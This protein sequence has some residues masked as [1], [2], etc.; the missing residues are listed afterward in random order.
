M[1]YDQ[2]ENVPGLCDVK[3]HI[4][5]LGSVLHVFVD[6]ASR[7]E[8]SARDI[9]SRI[10]S[11]TV[12][13]KTEIQVQERNEIT[14]EA[15]TKPSENMTQDTPV[16]QKTRRYPTVARTTVYYCTVLC[17]EASLVLHDDLRINSSIT[18]VLRI[19]LNNLVV[20]LRPKIDMSEKLRALN[21]KVREQIE[22]MVLVEDAQIDNQLSVHGRYDF[23]VIM[24]FKEQT[25]LQKFSPL[26]PIERV[27]QIAFKSSKFM[28][29][30]GLERTPFKQFYLHTIKIKLEPVRLQAEDVFFY[31][32]VD[33]MESFLSSKAE[34]PSVRC[35]KQDYDDSSKAHVCVILPPEILCRSNAISRP[36]NIQEILIDPISVELSVHASVKLYIALDQTP[37]NFNQ[38]QRRQIF[39]TSYSLGHNVAMHY[40]SGALVKAGWVVGSLEILGNPGGFARTVGSGMRDFVQ[41]PYEGILV[42]PWAFMAGIT[43]G[44]LSLVKHFTAGTVVSLT[45]L[46]SSVARNMDRLSLDNEH[47]ARTERDRRT[48]QPHGLMHGLGYGLATFGISLLGGIGG[49]AQQPIEAIMEGD[50]SAAGVVGGV[51]RGVLGA[52]TKPIGGA[53]D[54]FLHTGQGLL[55]GAG[56]QQEQQPRHLPP[57]VV[58]WG[59]ASNSSVKVSSKH[60]VALPVECRKVLISVEATL[61]LH[62]VNVNPV[63]VVLTPEMLYILC[64]SSDTQLYAIPILELQ[65]KACGSDPTLLLLGRVQA[66]KRKTR[67]SLLQDLMGCPERVHD[68]VFGTDS[69]AKLNLIQ[70]HQF[71]Q[72]HDANGGVGSPLAAETSAVTQYQAPIYKDPSLIQVEPDHEVDEEVQGSDKKPNLEAEEQVVEIKDG[73]YLVEG[74]T[75]HENLDIANPAPKDEEEQEETDSSE[76]ESVDSLVER[77]FHSEVVQPTLYSDV[78]GREGG[79]HWLQI[80][81]SPPLRGGLLSAIVL[82]RRVLQGKGFIV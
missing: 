72:N 13:A 24:H 14:K 77:F 44:S 36:I 8:V 49:L 78:V 6:S 66:N 48:S 15:S 70:D 2:F 32:L 42:G 39:T 73:V 18:E 52:L 61:M 20:S 54:L 29:S 51:G 71:V 40:L 45:N 1:K 33:I 43:H 31:S 21:F 62:N 79:C 5:R 76:D 46:A 74:I 26:D 12:Q 17:A 16:L 27:A 7:V 11:R 22:V 47:V 4:E 80:M 41:L 9:R 68:Y 63:T 55:K 58:S 75:S 82:A 53:A 30:F 50:V 19:T 3:V 67:D 64:C 25:E 59:A 65:C 35:I 28:A 60:L 69:S 56:W 38:Y 81:V 23:P 57:S 10:A 37:L 34:V